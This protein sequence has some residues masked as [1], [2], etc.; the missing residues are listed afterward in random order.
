[1]TNTNELN[2]GV[3]LYQK[4]VKRLEERERFVKDVKDIMEKKIKEEL[5]FKPKINNKSRQRDKSM[6]ALTKREDNLITYG[7]LIKEKKEKARI[8]VL[9]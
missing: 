3:R 9:H 7:K 5:L 1:M 4:G 2:I 6:G 8:E